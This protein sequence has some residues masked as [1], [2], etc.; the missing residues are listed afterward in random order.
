MHI[1]WLWLG[2]TSCGGELYRGYLDFITNLASFQLLYRSEWLTERVSILRLG[3]VRRTVRN[4][5]AKSTNQ[6]RLRGLELPATYQPLTL[7]CKVYKA[8]RRFSHPT[9]TISI[10]VLKSIPSPWVNAY[11]CPCRRVG[12]SV[13]LSGIM[14]PY[15]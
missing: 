5:V 6:L 4:P 12:V 11:P 15:I 10:L 2:A 1:G 8:R 3:S 13:V 9:P 14:G 7:K